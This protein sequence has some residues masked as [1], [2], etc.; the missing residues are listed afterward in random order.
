[1]GFHF[2]LFCYASE[3][4]GRGVQGTQA[5]SLLKYWGMSWS[6]GANFAALI[7]LL[8]AV[9]VLGYLALVTLKYQRQMR[10]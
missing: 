5:E 8:V 7:I 2:A 10:R 6:V 1:M 3:Q 9:T 4:L